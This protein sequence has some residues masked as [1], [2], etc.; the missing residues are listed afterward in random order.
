MGIITILEEG[1]ENPLSG[2]DV[3][4]NFAGNVGWGRGLGRTTADGNILH[5]GICRED[6][7]YDYY[8]IDQVYRT[9]RSLYIRQCSALVIFQTHH[10]V[11][12]SWKAVDTEY[13]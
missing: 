2:V 9:H 11:P 6:E 12:G 7:P 8:I 5:T 13:C 4:V 3:Y 1:T 10:L